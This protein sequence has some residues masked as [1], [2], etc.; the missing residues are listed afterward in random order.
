[1]RNR[2]I[3][4][5]CGLAA[6]SSMFVA[7][8]GSVGA[9]P[10]HQG[11]ADIAV[12]LPDSKS[13]VRWETADRKYLSAAFDAAGV[14]YSITNAQGDAAAQVTQADAAITNGAKVILLVDLDAASGATIIAKARAAKAAVIDYDRLTISGPGADFYVSFDGVA[15]GKVQGQGLVDAITA[16]G[17]KTP[18]VAILNGSP[19]DNNATLFSQGGH[20]I[21]DPLFTAKTYTNVAEQ[22]VPGWD[23]QK[24]LTI[25]EQML[26]STNNGI[27]AVLAA[28]DGLASSVISALKNANLKPIPLTGQDA[29]VAGIQNILAGW[30]SMTVYKAIKA[31]ANAAAA[32]AIAL[33]KG[34][35]TSKLATATVDQTAGGTNTTGNK[36]MPAVLLVPVSVTKANVADTVIADGFDSWAD[37]CV[38]DFAQY[39]PAG[40]MTAAT[41]A[42]TMAATAAK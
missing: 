22:A 23:N 34:T 24:A 26:T 7:S 8:A 4:L 41:A 37:I 6:A 40:A 27:D 17:I 28:N 16:A 25:F 18:R 20:S 11:K 14:T 32:L 38:G 39:C 19:T 9:A 31:E 30:Q 33:D 21:L 12:L 42:P 29:T 35:D 3:S 2:L 1:M 10:A 5:L 15:V 36:A 13:S